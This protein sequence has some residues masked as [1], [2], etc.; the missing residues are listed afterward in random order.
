[1]IDEIEP[2]PRARDALIALAG[3]GRAVVLTTSAKPEEADHYLDLLD[4]GDAISARVTSDDVDATKPEPDLVE[5]GR[6]RAGGGPAVMIGDSTW[7]CR[8]AG[9]A[10]VPCVAVLTGG[11]PEQELTAAGA[12]AVHRSLA[13]LIETI[14]DPPLRGG[15]RVTRHGVSGVSRAGTSTASFRGG[16]DVNEERWRKLLLEE[17]RRV[18]G[19]LERYRGELAAAP[20]P[21]V[22]VDR[23]LTDA[24]SHRYDREDAEG[25]IAQLEAR[26][27]AVAQAEERL[28]RGPWS[29]EPGVSR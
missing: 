8:A 11:F 3:G 10:G 5:A 28:R 20:E 16:A 19:D 14:D 15:G 4:A 24:A 6:R 1:M 12:V 9:R 22:S 29:G 26:L 7:D 13:E 2:L 18:E 25:R 27:A 21:P 17:R 23:L